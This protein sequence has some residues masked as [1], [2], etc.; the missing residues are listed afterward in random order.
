MAMANNA[1][2]III[3]IAASIITIIT[4]NNMIAVIIKV[5]CCLPP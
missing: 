5:Y 1:V 3:S 2:S 4:I